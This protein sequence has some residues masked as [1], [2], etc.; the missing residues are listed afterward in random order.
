M[1]EN[2]NFFEELL[3]DISKENKVTNIETCLISDEPLVEPII[4]LECGHK[5]NY[6]PLKNEVIRQK[7]FSNI[8]AI[9]KLNQK[10]IKCPYCRHVQSNLLP[11]FDNEEKLLGVNYPEKYCM[12]IYTCGYVFKSGKKKGE[13]CNKGCNK[14]MCKQHMKMKLVKDKKEQVKD[15]KTYCKAIIKTGVRAKK[16]GKNAHCLNKP[17]KDG[18]CMLHYNHYN[19]SE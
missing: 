9:C 7:H 10:Q 16:M 2:F 15:T 13:R 3:K 11:Y 6:E 5:F 1:I 4:V 12:N 14:E 19:K 18:Y 8:N 17:K